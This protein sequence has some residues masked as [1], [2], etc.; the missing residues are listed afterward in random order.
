MYKISVSVNVHVLPYI[1]DD[2]CIIDVDCFETLTQC[3]QHINERLAY[4]KNR[5]DNM[6][7]KQIKEGVTF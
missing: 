1:E 6:T 7:M 5:V 2:E 4:I 3:K